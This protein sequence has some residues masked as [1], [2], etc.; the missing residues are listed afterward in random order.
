MTTQHTPGPW[1]Y[2][3]GHDYVAIQYNNGESE[4]CV[5]RA[6]PATDG[7]IEADARLIAA[8]PE[9]LAACEAQR[10]AIDWLFA[11]LIGITGRQKTEKQF[12]PS[13]C[14]FAWDACVLGVAAVKK[15]GGA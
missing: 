6:F 2:H 8:A 14:G 13:K 4:L 9:L 5:Y 12:Y 7:R 1:S 10:Q 3:L 15:A 11:S